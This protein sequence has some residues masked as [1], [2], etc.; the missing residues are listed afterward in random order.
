M[1]TEELTIR[2]KELFEKFESDKTTFEESKRNLQNI[3]IENKIFVCESSSSLRISIFNTMFTIDIRKGFNFF[4][5]VFKPKYQKSI[6]LA[7]NRIVDSDLDVFNK[8][9]EETLNEFL[10]TYYDFYLTW[11]GSLKLSESNWFNNNEFLLDEDEQMSSFEC[12]T[13]LEDIGNQFNRLSKNDFK[14]ALKLLQ[15]YKVIFV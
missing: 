3:V 12:I 5:A 9:F 10:K 4:E 14:N 8:L 1:T 6:N 11:C 15:G 7:I 2:Y 13:K